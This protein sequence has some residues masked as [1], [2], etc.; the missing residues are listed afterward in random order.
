MYRALVRLPSFIDLI[1][2][3]AKK[4]VCCRDVCSCSMSKNLMPI[5]PVKNTMIPFL[6]LLA[7]FLVGVD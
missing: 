2:G 6:Q 5:S 1:I 4:S 7:A 3:K